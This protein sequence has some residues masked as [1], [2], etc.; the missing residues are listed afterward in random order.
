[1]VNKNMK[2]YVPQLTDS[3]EVWGKFIRWLF[4]GEADAILEKVNSNSRLKNIKASE[5]IRERLWRQIR[6]CENKK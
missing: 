4:D 2:V 1:M 6:E 3:D 5:E